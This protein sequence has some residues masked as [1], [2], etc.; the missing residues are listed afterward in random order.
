MM[1]DPLYSQIQYNNSVS[2]AFLLKLGHNVK[3]F[4]VE[5]KTATGKDIAEHIMRPAKVL[6]AILFKVSYAQGDAVYLNF[7]GI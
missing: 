1:N 4:L 6:P 7:G 5:M 2:N 3:L